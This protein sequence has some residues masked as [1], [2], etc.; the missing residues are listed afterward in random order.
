MLPDNRSR[1]YFHIVIA[2]WGAVLLLTAKRLLEGLQPG[3]YAVPGWPFVLLEQVTL[4]HG[5]QYV[6]LAAADGDHAR[7][8]RIVA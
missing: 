5:N 2:V 6:T 1:A 4:A 8:H 3:K 7:R